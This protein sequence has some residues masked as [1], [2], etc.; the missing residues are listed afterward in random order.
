MRAPD[1]LVLAKHLED[2]ARQL[3]T[4]GKTALRL[5]P[6]LAAR[7][8]PASTMGDGFRSAD[9]TSSVEREALH[10]TRQWEH[11]DL[12]LQQ[13][14]RYS[15]LVTLRLAELLTTICAH[16]GDDD[17]LPAGSGT[18]ERCARVVRPDVKPGDRLRAG[19]CNACYTAW[20]RGGKPDRFEYNHS[21]KESAA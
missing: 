4:T 6:E 1:P 18:C 12:H 7:G 10:G 15:W 19:Y 3:R 17:E 20:I 21:H 8:Y 14:L 13:R 2:V 9:T 5:A 11:V 16:A